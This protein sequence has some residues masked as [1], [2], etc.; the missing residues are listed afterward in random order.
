MNIKELEARAK[1]ILAAQQTVDL[2]GGKPLEL[3]EGD[4]GYEFAIRAVME[5]LKVP[6]GFVLVPVE[7]TP[8]M[9]ST[10]VHRQ[11]IDPLD[12]GKKMQ[13]AQLRRSTEAGDYGYQPWMIPPKTEY[14]VAAGKYIA[15]IEARPNIGEV[16]T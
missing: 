4:L 10:L 8:K 14:E 2:L 11:E 5:A 6:E 12:A 15:L 16:V 13:A 3:A 1:K 9:L 7:P